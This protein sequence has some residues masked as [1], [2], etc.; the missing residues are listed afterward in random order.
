M[1]PDPLPRLQHCLQRA[2]GKFWLKTRRTAASSGLAVDRLSCFRLRPDEKN[3]WEPYHRPSSLFNFSGSQLPLTSFFCFEPGA[4]Q[5]LAISSATSA[6]RRVPDSRSLFYFTVEGKHLCRW[7]AD[8]NP[9]I[10][11]RS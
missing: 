9:K 6:L 5:V 4:G 1:G 2:P 3:S 10:D 11:R 7:S 8:S